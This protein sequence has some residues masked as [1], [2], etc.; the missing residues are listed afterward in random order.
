MENQPLIAPPNDNDN[1]GKKK[2]GYAPMLYVAVSTAIL[3]L[4]LVFYGGEYWGSP[5]ALGVGTTDDDDVSP[6]G[7]S[8]T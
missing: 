4:G 2:K 5:R 7:D 8:C 3:L 1:V 6:F